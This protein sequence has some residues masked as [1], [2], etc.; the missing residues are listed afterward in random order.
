MPPAALSPSE[1]HKEMKLLILR[2][3][4]VTNCPQNDLRV[5]IQAVPQGSFEPNDLYSGKALISCST[6]RQLRC[7]HTCTV[8]SFVVSER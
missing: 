2:N 3:A 5:F 4:F 6:R 8:P 1:E 7:C